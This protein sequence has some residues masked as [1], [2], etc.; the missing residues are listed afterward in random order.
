LQVRVRS[1]IVATEIVVGA[2]ETARRATIR[3]S[4]TG[5]QADQNKTT[6]IVE[7]IVVE[8]AMAVTEI[9]GRVVTD[10]TIDL[11]AVA[12][13]VLRIEIAVT[14]TREIGTA[15]VVMTTLNEVEAE[16]K[17]LVPGFE[18]APTATSRLASE[19]AR[20]I[21]TR[22]VG[23]AA[24]ETG[25]RVA[26]T[27]EAGTAAAGT[28]VVVATTTGTGLATAATDSA[29][30]TDTE[31][32]TDTETVIRGRT[33]STTAASGRRIR[34]TS[35]VVMELSD[36]EMAARDGGMA[37]NDRET[38]VRN[39]GMEVNDPGMEVIDPGMLVNDPVMRVID[40]VMLVNDRE[41]EAKGLEMGVKGHEMRIDLHA[42]LIGV[43]RL[44]LILLPAVNLTETDHLREVEIRRMMTQDT[45]IPIVRVHR[46]DRK[47]DRG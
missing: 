12:A 10:S 19:T 31:R 8:I 41:M 29:T 45:I 30:V 47:S 22:E 46:I 11:V 34:A 36:R 26:A 21:G 27:R 16:T 1:E 39:G 4:E 2:T 6:L 3:R 37:A 38:V 28:V 25:T 35:G 33:G 32:T 18:T 15:V 17:T 42:M 13:A 20:G 7:A 5:A 40:L 23:T 44:I 9:A 24:A 14:T 43:I